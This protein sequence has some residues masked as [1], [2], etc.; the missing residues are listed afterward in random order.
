MLARFSGLVRQSTRVRLAAVQ[1]CRP[2]NTGLFAFARTASTSASTR[3]LHTTGVVTKAVKSG[4]GYL[5]TGHRSDFAMDSSSQRVLV[6]GCSGQVGSE[7]LLALMDTYGVDNVIASDIKKPSK[8]L[9]CQFVYLDV[10]NRDQIARYVC[11]VCSCVC[12]LL[13]LYIVM[14][15]SWFSLEIYSR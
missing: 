10:M 1:R 8:R 3:A 12:S 11:Y 15:D 5:Q 2:Q 14:Y 13:L 7:V 4:G 6:T 9:A